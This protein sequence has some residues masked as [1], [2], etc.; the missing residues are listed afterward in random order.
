MIKEHLRKM[1]Y[2]VT[3]YY[4]NHED[5]TETARY[6]ATR[7]QLVDVEKRSCAVCGTREHLEC[8]HY[9]VEWADSN[10]VD[11]KSFQRQH[12]DL[13][14]WSQFDDPKDFVD[15]PENMMILCATHHRHVNHGIHAVPFP[16]WQLQRHMRAGFKFA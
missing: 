4:P 12:P 11:W 8:H 5:R 3:R 14:D 10:A 13:V 9:Y 6:R 15:C 2:H 1:T 16:S 7:H